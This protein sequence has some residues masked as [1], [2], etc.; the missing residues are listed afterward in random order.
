MVGSIYGRVQA[1]EDSR[2]ADETIAA[3]DTEIGTMRSTIES[4]TTYCS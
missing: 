4:V 3:R 1:A 2:R